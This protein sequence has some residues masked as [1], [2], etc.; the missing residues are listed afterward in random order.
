M[1]QQASGW[2]PGCDTP[3]LKRQ[4]IEEFHRIEGI[5][6]DELQIEWNPA[7]RQIAKLLL[8]R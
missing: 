8:N 1:K 7:L 2:P 3:E 6:M 5:L 4:Y